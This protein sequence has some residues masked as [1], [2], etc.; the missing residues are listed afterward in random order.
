MSKDTMHALRFHDYGGPEVLVVDR[1]PR[2]QPQVNEVLVRLI[3]SGVNPWDWKLRSGVYKEFIPLQLPA[4]LGIEAAG[5][6]EQVGEEVTTVEPGQSVFG[7]FNNNANAE[8]AVV[9]AEDLTPKPTG[10]TFEEA[11]SVP[12]GAL[13]AWQAVIEVA[14]VQSGQRVLVH[15]AA[16]GVGVYAVQLAKW[17]GATVIGTTSAANAEF[18]RS[19]GVDLVIDYNAAPF[20][21][22]V[23]DVDVVIDT[24][25]GEIP[26]RSLQVLR[27]DGVLVS[28]AARLTPESGQ[29]HGVRA[30]GAGRASADKLP[31]IAELLESKKI[32]AVVG[33]I[34][35]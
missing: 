6:V 24:V 13:T 11:A 16:G 17:K 31:K 14:K 29:A 33:A 2:P 27:K 28:V 8:Y 10:L 19:L 23:R 34:F 5:I 7:T 9:P 21:T 25:G 15:G 3:A 20:E 32:K 18:A 30:T 12:V 1:V 22:V 35:P 4:T 26:E